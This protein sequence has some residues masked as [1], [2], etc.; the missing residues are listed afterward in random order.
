[1]KRI[2][3][4]WLTAPF[5]MTNADP[6]M[7]Q[8]HRRLR[9]HAHAHAHSVHIPTYSIDEA[10]E[11][12]VRTLHSQGFSIAHSP[13]PTTPSGSNDTPSQ[14]PTRVVGSNDHDSSGSNDMPSQQPTSGLDA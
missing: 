12:V 14:Q 6:G 5:L 3:A 11:F 7:I 1:M 4:I 8:G 10:E 2:S 13:E 9:R